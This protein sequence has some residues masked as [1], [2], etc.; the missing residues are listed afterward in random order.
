MSVPSD[1]ALISDMASRLSSE[2]LSFRNGEISL[3]F[4]CKLLDFQLE[5]TRICEGLTVVD[6]HLVDESI[7]TDEGKVEYMSAL[8]SGTLPYSKMLCYAQHDPSSFFGDLTS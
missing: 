7:L 6:V 3:Q 4:F 5:I 1:L 2:A 8:T